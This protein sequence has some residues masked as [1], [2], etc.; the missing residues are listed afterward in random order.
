LGLDISGVFLPGV[1]MN[2]LP[3]LLLLFFLFFPVKFL[4]IGKFVSRVQLPLWRRVIIFLCEGLGYFVLFYISYISYIS[5]LLYY[6]FGGV[7]FGIGSVFYFPNY[8]PLRA[9]CAVIL[10]I[11]LTMITRY[12]IDPSFAGILILNC[13][14]CAILGF[15]IS[16]VEE[17]SRKAWLTIVYKTGKTSS[18][19][20]GKTPV[21]FGTSK[22][23]LVRLPRYSFDQNA[24]DIRAIFTMEYDGGIFV[25]D[26]L[27][28]TLEQLT[29]GSCVDLGS[30][31]IVVHIAGRKSP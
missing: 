9:L 31:S 26:R 2:L 20:L 5:V 4:F 3:I 17:A 23:A 10:G 27:T 16:F 22:K 8:P 25:R 30:A 18:V 21:S 11:L 1:F 28:G 13:V 29:N 15:T 24:P 6:V 14:Y 19:A 7:L 12:F